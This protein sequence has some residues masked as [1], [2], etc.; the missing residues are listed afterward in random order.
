M[1]R[2]RRDDGASSVI[3]PCDYVAIVIAL[4]VLDGAGHGCGSWCTQTPR[5]CIF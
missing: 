5:R 2:D 1:Q 3:V 4:D